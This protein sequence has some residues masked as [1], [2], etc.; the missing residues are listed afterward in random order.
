MKDTS[1]GCLR[2]YGRK[3]PGVA[4]GLAPQKQGLS[5]DHGVW[6]GCVVQPVDNLL[7]AWSKWTAMRQK[8]TPNCGKRLAFSEKLRG[9]W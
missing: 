7:L 8:T 1:D 6:V 2:L 3:D 4:S 5:T 9:F